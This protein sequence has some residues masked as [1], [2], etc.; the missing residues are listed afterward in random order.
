MAFKLCQMFIMIRWYYRWML[1]MLS[2]SFLREPFLSCFTW[3][4]VS[5]FNFS[6][7]F[8]PF[9]PCRFPF[10]ST[11]ISLWEICQSSIIWKACTKTICLGP[12]F[13]LAHFCVL[14]CSMQVFHLIFP[15]RYRQHSHHRPNLYF[16]FD[17]FVS[18]LAS[19]GFMVQLHKCLS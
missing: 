14:Q 17:H 11:T 5:C 15:F 7:L 4:E 16:V 2:T 19:V 13:L 1:Q 18:W 9:M 6:P 8:N 12:L 3:Q 10:S